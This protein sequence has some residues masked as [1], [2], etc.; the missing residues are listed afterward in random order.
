MYMNVEFTLY[1][2]PT[3]STSGIPLEHTYVLSVDGHNWNCFGAGRGS[4]QSR[5][6]RKA[7]GS[8]K[9]ASLIYGPDEGAQDSG[10]AAGLSIRYDGVCQNAANRIL[11]I[12]GDE[13]DARDTQGNALATLTYGKFGFNLSQYIDRV[14]STGQQLLKNDPGEITQADIDTV[15]NR[16][17]RGLSADDELDILHADVQE[18][19]GTHLSALTDTQRKDFDTIYI[20]FQ[21]QR[22][23]AFDAA[24]KQASGQAAQGP[25][26]NNL[27]VPL[28]TCFGRLVEVLGM[29]GFQAMFGVNPALATKWLIG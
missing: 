20:D 4:D 27:K 13:I 14:K 22:S 29:D 9:W 16:I 11:V 25:L 7:N 23:A 26:V 17:T 3:G 15:T 5:I 19:M 12:T 24:S 6:V 1:A 2:R 18:Q 8:S 21:A 28:T 10:T